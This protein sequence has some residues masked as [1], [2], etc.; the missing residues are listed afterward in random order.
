LA[1]PRNG[2]YKKKI[3]TNKKNNRTSNYKKSTRSNTDISRSI[4]ILG[5]YAEIS[6]KQ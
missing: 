5:I 6:K 1:T 3:F 2:V 4:R